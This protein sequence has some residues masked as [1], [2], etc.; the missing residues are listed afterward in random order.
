MDFLS[1]RGVLSKISTTI[2]NE[3]TRIKSDAFMKEHEDL[4]EKIFTFTYHNLVEVGA[5]ADTT[6]NKPSATDLALAKA[7]SHDVA[8]G[9]W[10]GSGQA[11][12]KMFSI[13]TGVN[14]QQ[15]IISNSRV[16]V[17]PYS[18]FKYEGILGLCTSNSRH[19]IIDFKGNLVQN[20]SYIKK[21]EHMS[22]PTREEIAYMLGEMYLSSSEKTKII[23]AHHHIGTLDKLMS[24]VEQD[25]NRAKEQ[26]LDA[27]DY[28]NFLI[29]FN[30]NVTTKE[31]IVPDTECTALAVI[32]PQMALLSV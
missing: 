32:E 27:E 28:R 19:Y 17:S 15:T 8:G 11:I 16:D 23:L 24:H 18:F 30:P 6:L 26:E 1:I 21:V 3:T 14:I 29:P 31:R 13:L 10:E 20:K 7:I 5:I 12:I 2:D 4:V 25:I 9:D 22:M